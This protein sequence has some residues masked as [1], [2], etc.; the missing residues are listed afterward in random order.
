MLT[1]LY[2]KVELVIY[3][4]VT[5]SR[6]QKAA[7][8]RVTNQKLITSF[9]KT[10]PAIGS[11]TPIIPPITSTAAPQ[12][13]PAKP[14]QSTTPS[15]GNQAQEEVIPF[16]SERKDGSCSGT[17]RAAAEEAKDKEEANSAYKAEA[18]ANNALVFP[19]NFCDPSDIYA[20]P[21]A[22]ATK[23]FHKLTEAEKW[24][25][26]KDLLKMPCFKMHGANLMLNLSRLSNTRKT[27]ASS[28]TTFYTSAR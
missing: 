12:P 3:F 9:I 20:T 26:E 25:L 13:S 15:T 24:D 17:K 28:L 19:E 22:Y 1:S 6:S 4:F 14:Q 5:W 7:T 27:H 23:V 21:K 18:P 11:N 2:C 10:S 8:S 16:R